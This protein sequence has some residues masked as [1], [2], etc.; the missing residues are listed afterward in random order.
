MAAGLILLIPAALSIVM[1][2]AVVD[3]VDG[4]IR[5]F[6]R[7][8]TQ[9]FPGGDWIDYVPAVG[10]VLLVLILLY[11]AG[12]ITRNF[13]GR[14]IVRSLER[15][16]GRV[17][18]LSAIYGTAREATSM[19]SNDAGRRFSRVVL[20]TYPHPGAKSLGFV[21]GTFRSGAGKDYSMVYVPT[22]PTPMSG[23]LLFV[24]EAEMEDAGVSVD[25][26]MR[27]VITGG[28]LSRLQQPGAVPDVLTHLAKDPRAP[29]PGQRPAPSSP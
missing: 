16:V 29:Q 27:M 22:T 26:A 21:T 12:L 13:I 10:S 19:F 7:T 17:P 4:L 2:R 15:L 8:L 23:F 14:R 24:T 3:F 20:V 28:I 6:T 18:V 11:F 1:L 9:G 25:A 5:P